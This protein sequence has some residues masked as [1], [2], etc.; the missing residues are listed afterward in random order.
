MN[1][2]LSQVDYIFC[3]PFSD[4][5][6]SY[7]I[8]SLDSHII[9]R[10]EVISLFS[11]LTLTNIHKIDYLTSRFFSFIFIA[12][13][14]EIVPLENNTLSQDEVKDLLDKQIKS[15]INIKTLDSNLNENNKFSII[16][17][18][19]KSLSLFLK[20]KLRTK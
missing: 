18:F 1:I 13:K 5:Y 16:S 9:L 17:N 20:E 3:K 11:S 19:S 15:S 14:D 7:S 4:K 6:Y 10:E 8:N 2:N 12:S